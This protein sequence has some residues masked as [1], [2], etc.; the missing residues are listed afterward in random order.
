MVKSPS[1]TPTYT[2]FLEEKLPMAGDAQR[3][4]GFEEIGKKL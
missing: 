4:N 3:Q 1:Y 2:F